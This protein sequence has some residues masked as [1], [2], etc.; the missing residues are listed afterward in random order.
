MSKA[1]AAARVSLALLVP[2]GVHCVIALSGCNGAEAIHGIGA[3]VGNHDAG[4]PIGEG[5]QGGQGQ[6]QGGQGGVIVGVDAGG[7]GG[8]GGS[9][10]TPMCPDGLKNG[11][12]T[13]VD[14][15]GPGCPT[16]KVG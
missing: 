1:A 12:E 7:G 5:G 10:V 2:L 4:V 6:G 9:P 11:T 8:S 3:N 13:D 15:G 16:C 14:C